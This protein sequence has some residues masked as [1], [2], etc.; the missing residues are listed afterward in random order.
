MKVSRQ[1]LSSSLGAAVK[2]T[3]CC[4]KTNK[5]GNEELDEEKEE[6]EE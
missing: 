6:Q 5:R 2:I 1:S 3:A 4:F